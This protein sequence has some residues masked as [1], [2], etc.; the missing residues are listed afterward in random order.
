MSAV[1]WALKFTNGPAAPTSAAVASPT[2]AS[3]IDAQA[4]TKGLGGG[5]AHVDKVRS[6]S[7]DAPSTIQA[8]RFVLTGVVV[9]KTSSA[10]AGQ[11]V[12][13]IAVDGKPPRPFRVNSVLTEG[14]ILH[15]VSAGKAMLSTSQEASPSLNLELP[16]L[17]SAVAGT[18]I[19]AR[20][21]VAPAVI[22]G[23]SAAN[24]TAAPATAGQRPPR[25]P[26][27][28]QRESEKEAARDQAAQ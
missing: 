16:R 25:P 6:D 5:K 11:G 24:A 9:Q 27:I 28:R 7:A 17:T 10:T 1:Y 3:T 4:L 19:A 8:S 12:A 15:S 20:P 23:N 14:V 26:A 13:L 18:A 2:A 22:T 21:A